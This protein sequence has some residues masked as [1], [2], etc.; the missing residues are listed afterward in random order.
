V[1][2]IMAALTDGEAEELAATA[3][4]WGMDVL[5][6]VHDRAEMERALRL[7]APLV[8]INNRNLKTLAI[9]LGTTEALAPL[10]PAGRLLVS[11]SGLYAPADLERMARSGARCF[12]VG[13]SLMRQP[14]VA[15]A[16]RALLARPGA[17]EGL[18]A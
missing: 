1:L 18:L 10:V 14:D 6:E 9:D 4:D 5:V 15:A 3:R 13:E 16:T 12:L 17:A 8:G 11:E 7:D 2:L